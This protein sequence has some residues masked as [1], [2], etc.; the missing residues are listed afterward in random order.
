VRLA[1]AQ[2]LVAI[3]LFG[4]L[5]FLLSVFG[6]FFVPYDPVPGVS[7]GV[8]VAVV[9]NYWVAMAGRRVYDGLAGAV[10]PA[11]I[12]LAVTLTLASGRAEGD[13]VLSNSTASLAFI[14]LGATSS[15]VG[16]GRRLP[17]SATEA[18]AGADNGA[19]R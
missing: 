12:W 17:P 11:L 1:T 5:S 4:F 10:L 7:V 15:A 9:G 8:L 13:V 16:I 3:V 14:V 2:R 19:P 6:A 18:D